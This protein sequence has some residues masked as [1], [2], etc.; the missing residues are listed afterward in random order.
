[1]KA[2]YAWEHNGDDTI[3][4]LTD[5]IGAYARGASLADA[6]AKLPGELAAYRRW[7]DGSASAEAPIE[8][9]RVQELPSR[10]MIA[11]AD[12]SILLETE[13]PPMTMDEYLALK[14]L[15]L[16][17]AGDFLRLYEA[18]PDRDASA[19]PRRETFYGP[20]PR[21]AREMYE[22]TKNVNEY[23][24][25]EIGVPADNAGDIADGRARAFATLEAMPGFLDNALHDNPA[26]GDREL[27]TLRKVCRRFLWHDRI[28]AKAMLRM[29]V[30]TFGPGCVPD[31][32]HFKD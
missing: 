9:I 26:W 12:S 24:F 23:Y 21:T 27:W 3:L 20:V 6:L 5:E 10:L 22:H 18:V 19:L 13:R 17:S 30:A 7:R 15:T 4:W 8:P 14:A 32:Y 31:V 25:G 1:M 2:P 28:H 29:A 11:D 16:R